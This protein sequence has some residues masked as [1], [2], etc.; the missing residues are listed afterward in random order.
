V[1]SDIIYDTPKTSDKPDT[2]ADK[3]APYIIIGIITIIFNIIAYSMAYICC[4][5]QSMRSSGHGFI[6]AKVVCD[7][8]D[9]DEENDQLNQDV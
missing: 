6:E 2:F 9:T 7:S 3:Y 5:K 4:I 1:A 8:D